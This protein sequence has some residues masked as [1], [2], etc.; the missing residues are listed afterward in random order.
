MT[1]ERGM[2]SWSGQEGVARLLPRQVAA[3]IVHASCVHALRLRYWHEGLSCLQVRRVAT[4][5]PTG[6]NQDV[7]P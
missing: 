5:A 1:V 6:R 7:F 2:G 3:D 4:E